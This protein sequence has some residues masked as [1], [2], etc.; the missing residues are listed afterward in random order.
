LAC[1]VVV[2]DVVAVGGG[3]VAV[4]VVVVVYRLLCDVATCFVSVVVGVWCVCVVSL[5]PF[6]TILVRC[7]RHSHCCSF[8]ARCGCR[9][10]L[11]SGVW[12]VCMVFFTVHYHFTL[13]QCVVYVTLTAICLQVSEQVSRLVDGVRGGAACS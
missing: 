8:T 6:N 11:L 2:V 4:V 13:F 12:C 7:L 3:G 5:L 10:V 9:L 1:V